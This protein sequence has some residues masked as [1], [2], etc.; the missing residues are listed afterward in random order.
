MK[1]T[2]LGLFIPLLFLYVIASLPSDFCL[3]QDESWTESDQT[4]DPNIESDSSG[5]SRNKKRKSRSRSPSSED[6]EAITDSTS[7]LSSGELTSEA[8]STTANSGSSSSS[9]P[10]PQIGSTNF[11]AERYM[12][13]WRANRYMNS[14]GYNSLNNV[15]QYDAWLNKDIGYFAMG[16]ISKDEDTATE[17]KT[18]VTNNIGLSQAYT[19]S[20]SGSKKPMILTLG[21][22]VK[23]RLWQ[24]EWIQIN[25]GGMGL[26]TQTSAVSYPYAGNIVKTVANTQ[27]PNDYSTVFTDVGTVSTSASTAIRIGPRLGAEV[28]LKWFPNVSVVGDIQI[29]MT[30]A[31]TGT[32]RY[33]YESKTY[34][35]TGGVDQPAS[36][37]TSTSQSQQTKTGGAWDTSQIGS[38]VFN[39]LSATWGIRYNW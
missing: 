12:Q 11:I 10:T 37:S 1:N 25:W 4:P 6:T 15:I 26:L 29:L 2:K 33:A 36:S 18:V 39:A 16:S 21:G 23:F 22:G 7:S 28:Y 34:A 24:N 17:T 35:T 14:F 3:A 5:R 20:Y 9:Q 8:A 19:T 13:S 31:Q 38:S 30:M 32:T 27:S